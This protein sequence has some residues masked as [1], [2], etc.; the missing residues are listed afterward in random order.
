MKY[1]E[2][3]VLAVAASILL[4]VVPLFSN[5]FH[6]TSD[7]GVAAVNARHILINKE[8]VLR[9]PETSIRGIYAGPLWYYFNAL[10]YA[11]TSGHPA[12]GIVMMIILH[13][14]CFYVVAKWAQGL[15]KSESLLLI[16]GMS[17]NWW[18]FDT[19]RYAFN[20]F[21]LVTLVLLETMLLVGFLG[22]ERKKYL[23]ALVFIFLAYNTHLVGAIA[24]VAIWVMVGI[25]K[26]KYLFRNIW[27]WAL[28]AVTA[29]VVIYAV[30]WKYGSIVAGAGRLRDAGFGEALTG[31][32]RILGRSVVP[33]FWQAGLAGFGLISFIYWRDKQKKAFEARFVAITLLFSAIL[34]LII[35]LGR[36]YREWYLVSL[37]LIVFISVGVM[38]FRFKRIG[39]IVF[40]LIVVLHLFNFVTSYKQAMAAYGSD[41]STLKNQ[42]EVLDRVYEMAGGEGFAAYTYTDSY[43][44]YP[45][46]YLFWWY[47]KEK[48]GYLPCEYSNLPFVDK[49]YVPGRTSFVEP[50]K[51]CEKYKFLIVESETNGETNKDWTHDFRLATDLVEARNVSQVQI[52]K[53]QINPAYNEFYFLNLIMRDYRENEMGISLPVDW[54][55]EIS[56]GVMRFENKDKSISV[57]MR[58]L[59]KDCLSMENL[60]EVEILYG[61]KAESVRQEAGIIAKYFGDKNDYLVRIELMGIMA[62]SV[63][64]PSEILSSVKLF[65]D[66]NTVLEISCVDL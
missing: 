62:E 15:G 65:E 44:D 34:V 60:G 3:I 29:G 18:F 63:K 31:V 57:V 36:I 21:P 12:G 28:L 39:R 41:K 19:A 43:F 59:K 26:Y 61:G 2:I 6:F 9:G 64:L 51:W 8:P 38:L 47:G 33:Q 20:P 42:L 55:S 24:M 10:G 30:Y 17:V 4:R 40:G 49:L 32:L 1:R 7:Q 45:Q 23:A 66:E 53:R 50:K 56:P 48:F 52:E 5:N 54:R 46:Q 13:L 16:L 11:I 25:W 14:V 37:P 27:G 58:R 22:G 35:G